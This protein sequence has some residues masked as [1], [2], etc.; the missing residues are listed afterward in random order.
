L[1]NF[2]ESLAGKVY[3]M[4]SGGSPPQ[5]RGRT[6]SNRIA[7]S[8]PAD[9]AR[10]ALLLLLALFGVSAFAWVSHP[11]VRLQ[12]GVSTRGRGSRMQAK[13]SRSV[14]IPLVS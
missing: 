9:M 1:I 6:A 11:R 4:L 12:G 8:R 3:K 7:A 5:Q 14:D 10:Q 13:V 2:L